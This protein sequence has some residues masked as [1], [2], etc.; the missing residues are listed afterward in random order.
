MIQM[1]EMKEMSFEELINWAQS[2][3]WEKVTSEEWNVYN[4]QCKRLAKGYFFNKD[5]SQLEEFYR[6]YSGENIDP[7]FDAWTNSLR[8]CFPFSEIYEKLATIETSLGVLLK[9][10]DKEPANITVG[11]LNRLKRGV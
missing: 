4:S 9:Q 3:D 10:M 1:K 5:I 6:T 8:D 11:Q 2:A 7:W